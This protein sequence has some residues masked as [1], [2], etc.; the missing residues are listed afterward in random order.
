VWALQLPLLVELRLFPVW[1]VPLELRARLVEWLA[2][3]L[4][5]E[6]REPVQQR[7]RLLEQQPL[8]AAVLLPRLDLADSVVVLWRRRLDRVLYFNHRRRRGRV[9]LR[10]HRQHRLDS[11]APAV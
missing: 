8:E 10:P 5:P 3:V 1:Q 4:Q 2:L 9:D 6:L 7:G 11:R